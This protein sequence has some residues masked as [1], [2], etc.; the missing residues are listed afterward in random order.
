ME[1]RIGVTGAPL[2][3]VSIS[4]VAGEMYRR[5]YGPATENV[6]P[7]LEVT[8]YYRAENIYHQPATQGRFNAYPTWPS[9]AAACVV[10]VDPE[11]GLIEVLDYYLVE[12]AGTIVNPLLVDAN[13]HG[14]TAQA[15]GGALYEQIGYDE[16]GQILSATLMDYTIP[17]AV[18]MPR[19]NVAHQ[20]FPSPFTPL[21]TKARGSPGWGARWAPWSARWRT[22]SGTTTSASTRSR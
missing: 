22:P 4:E 5:P 14:A 2:R 18:E 1:G 9:A 10:A 11:T 8:R 15:L 19:V 3:S 21:G 20:V 6:E 13:L 17:T 16:S 7:G 12:D